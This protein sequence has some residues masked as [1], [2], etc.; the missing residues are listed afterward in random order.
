MAWLCFDPCFGFLDVFC[1]WH[2]RLSLTYILV[3]MLPRKSSLRVYSWRKLITSSILDWHEIFERKVREENTRCS[4]HSVLIPVTLSLNC[5]RG[6]SSNMTLIIC[7]SHPKKHRRA[8]QD[9]H[10]TRHFFHLRSHINPYRARLLSVHL[11]SS[12]AW[13][14]TTSEHHSMFTAFYNY[15]M[16]I[17]HVQPWVCFMYVQRFFDLYL[18]FTYLGTNVASK[19]TVGSYNW[20]KLFHIKLILISV[21]AVIVVCIRLYIHLYI[22]RLF[23]LHRCLENECS[24]VQ[25]CFFFF[26]NYLLRATTHYT[27][28][29][30]CLC[31]SG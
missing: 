30:L 14:F 7:L 6:L 3:Q 19:S 22:Q 31:M 13:G 26:S 15:E 20:P 4:L 5:R 8:S 24:V 29:R 16:Q 17:L 23:K 10:N 1:V 9:I 27:I 18:S 25:Y 12:Y 28:S 2:P 11:C 21:K